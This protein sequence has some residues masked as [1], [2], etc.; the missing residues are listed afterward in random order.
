MRTA[1][2]PEATTLLRNVTFAA[3]IDRAFLLVIVVD[4]TVKPFA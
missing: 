1:A 4:M 3:R 2:D